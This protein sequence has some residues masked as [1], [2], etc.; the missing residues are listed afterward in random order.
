M[1]ILALIVGIIV[2]IVCVVAVASMVEAVIYDTIGSERKPLMFK[3]H[4]RLFH[5]ER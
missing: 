1:D 4:M 3:V 2:I 5:G